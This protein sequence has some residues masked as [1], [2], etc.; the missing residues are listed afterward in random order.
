MHLQLMHE[1]LSRFSENFAAFLYGLNMNAFCVDF[2]E[3]P[4]S[5][6]F[7]R[8]KINDELNADGQIGASPGPAKPAGR[9]GYDYDPDMT[10]VS[11]ATSFVDHPSTVRSSTRN[12]TPR[13]QTRARGGNVTRGIARGA[14]GGR[15]TAGTGR[16]RPSGIARGAR[17]RG[18]R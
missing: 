6:S 16:T 9:G 18:V 14:N 4:V 11:T 10:I 13:G 17:G 2:P 8:A 3:A 7:K 5:D 12:A 15:G 1:S